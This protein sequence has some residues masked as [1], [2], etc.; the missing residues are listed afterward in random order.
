MG[1]VIDISHRLPKRTDSRADNPVV[2]ED[3]YIVLY[4]SGQVEYTELGRETWSDAFDYAGIDID[5]VQTLNQHAEALERIRFSQVPP[6][7][8]I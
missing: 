7:G 6:F 5:D 2:H 3:P 1:N 4:Y 8:R